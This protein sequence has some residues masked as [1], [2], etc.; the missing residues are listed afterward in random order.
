MGGKSTKETNRELLNDTQISTSIQK[1]N[2]RL[3]DTSL[4]IIQK[5][6]TNAAASAVVTQGVK[7][8]NMTVAGD[9]IIKNVDTSNQI[10][11]GLSSLSDTS[12]KQELVTDIQDELGLKI[13]D[14]LQMTQEQSQQNGEQMISEAISGLVQAAGTLGAVMGADT[15]QKDNVNI[16]NFLNV[17]SE[18]ELISDI[19]NAIS[20]EL[21]NETVQNLSTNLNVDQ[22][23]EASGLNVGGNYIVSDISQT[24]F[25]EMTLDAVSRSGLVTD[26]IAKMIN[27][28]KTDVDKTLTVTQTQTQ[29]DQGTL[30]GI[31]DMFATILGGMSWPLIIGMVVVLIVLIVVVMG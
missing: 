4:E 8:S 15:E 16:S 2:K 31:G 25:A 1:I 29:Q 14:M 5:N 26:V 30:Q 7:L 9:V 24:N 17:D 11:I 12:L 10:T 13:K 23:I 20:T 22:S 27:V 28:D 19:R 3:M 18:I 21:L 6:V